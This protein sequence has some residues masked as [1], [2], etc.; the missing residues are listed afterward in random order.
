MTHWYVKYR[1]GHRGCRVP[2]LQFADRLFDQTS[3]WLT[4][5]VMHPVF[6]L[7][8][9]PGFSDLCAM[10]ARAWLQAAL[11]LVQ[12]WRSLS[13]LFFVFHARI[14]LYVPKFGVC[15][16]HVIMPLANWQHTPNPN[17]DSCGGRQ[18]HTSIAL[19]VSLWSI[20]TTAC[21]S[22]DV[23]S[24]LIA[25]QLAVDVAVDSSG[26]A[27]C[28][29]HFVMARSPKVC[30][31]RWVLQRLRRDY[32]GISRTMKLTSS[33]Q[34]DGRYCLGGVLLLLLGFFS[35]T[36]PVEIYRNLVVDNLQTWWLR[37]QGWSIWPAKQHDRGC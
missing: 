35:H 18:I 34:L 36:W 37:Y 3:G 25:I 33:Y 19:L 12:G 31:R 2:C 28:V 1:Y 27:L 13:A 16:V 22:D 20:L 10:I 4:V 23:L 32:S 24:S 15:L 26:Q 6:S 29:P 17:R 30:R 5:A 7:P 21:S 9:V 8:I 11:E 14:Q